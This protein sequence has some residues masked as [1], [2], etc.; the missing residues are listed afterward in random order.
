MYKVGQGDVLLSCRDKNDPVVAL[1]IS[2]D[3]VDVG[4]SENVGETGMLVLVSP[5]P[6]TPYLP[7]A[8]T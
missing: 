6:A 5:P 3:G 2:L 1:S 7:Q 4:A 8:F